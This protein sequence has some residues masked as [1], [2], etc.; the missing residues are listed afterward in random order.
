MK[1][2]RILVVEDERIVSME[3][4]DKLRDLGYTVVAS[5]SNG[6][7]A[8]KIAKIEL[9]DII[10]MDIKLKGEM[11]GIE[12]AAI[13]TSKS[14][15][16]VIFLTAYADER[17][18]QRAKHSNPYGYLLKPFETREL[19]TTVEMALYRSRMERRIAESEQWLHTTLI[20]IGDAVIATDGDKRIKFMNRVAENLTGW[21]LK[22]AD[23][24]YVSE[25]FNI[26][27][28]DT[29]ESI[30]FLDT[31]LKTTDN[32]SLITKK[33]DR[34]Q[35]EY[36]VSPLVSE[37][38]AIEGKVL[39]FRDI[40]EKKRTEKAIKEARDQ[41]RERSKALEAINN[42]LTAEIEEHNRTGKALEESEGKYYAL[43]NN[44]VDPIIIFD[45]KSK[46][47]VH[48]NESFKKVYGYSDKEIISMTPFD[49]HPEEE[50]DL[51]ES[52]ID[53]LSNSTPNCY[54][55][56]TKDG[57]KILVE[58]LTHEIEYQGKP[59]WMTI[60]R[61]I[62]GRKEAEEEK[63]R[64]I[65]QT[66]LINEVGRY[67]A[68]ELNH[69]RLMDKI[70]RAVKKTF[71]FDW[72]TLFLSDTD[73]KKLIL[74][75]FAGV[76]NNL[77]QK[78]DEIHFGKGM[79]GMAKSTGSVQ[80]SNDVRKNPYYI[81][82]RDEDILSELAIPIIG[83]RQ[84]VLGV[85]DIQSK[86]LNAFSQHDVE[87]M[88]ALS[89]QIAAALENAD[90]YKQVR[91]ELAERKKAEE[92]MRKLKEF[93][94]RILQNMSEGV[95]LET[96]KGMLL[97]VN[98]AAA[99]MLGDSPEYLIGKHWRDVIPK[100]LYSQV[101]NLKDKMKKDITEQL[102]LEIKTKRGK[103]VPV[104][105]SSSYLYNGNKC[106][107]MIDVLTDIT[108][109]KKVQEQLKRSAEDL[110]SAKELQD[111]YTK[112]LEE[113][114]KELERAKEKAEEATRLKSEF[115]A[116][117][118]HEIRTPMNGVIGMTELALDT[119]LDPVQRDYLKAVYVSAESLLTLIND[120]LDFSKMEAGRLGL[121]NINFSL[122]NV[123]NS[124]V[125][126]I[127]YQAEKKNIELLYTISPEI[128][129]NLIGDPGRIR[130]I[131]INL[132]SNALKFTEE[133]EV[134]IRVE[135]QAKVRNDDTILHFSVTDS[136]IGIPKEKQKMI[137]DVFTQADGSTTRKY[138]GT[139]LG[140]AISSKLV[141]MMG[142]EIWV[143][144]PAKHLGTD[145]GGAGSTFHFTLKL[146]VSENQ[147]SEK[148]VDDF[149][150]AG[151]KI[152][153]VDDN[154]TNLQILGDTLKKWGGRVVL[155]SGGR[156]ALEEIKK[157]EEDG[158][159]FDIVLVDAH[160]PDMDGFELA[161]KIAEMEK[162]TGVPVMMVS[163]SDIK[164]HKDKLDNINISCYVQKPLRQSDLKCILM[165]L[166]SKK[167]NR[168]D[169]TCNKA[170]NTTMAS[171]NKKRSNEDVKILLAE[172]N[173]INRKL[174]A[175]LIAKKG[176]DI[177]SVEDGEECVE[178]FKHG[179]FNIILMDVQMPRMD[180]VEA[181]RKIREIDRK[182]NIHTPIIAMTAHAMKGDR[183]KFLA[184]GMD[185]YI[186]KPMK[187]AQLYEIIG[188]YFKNREQQEVLTM[189]TDL[190]NMADVMEAVDGD[191][192]L[193]RELVHDF[194]R[195][196]PEQLDELISA[197]R[198]S[199]PLLVERKAHSFKG[200]V[201]NFG[202]K[203]VQQLAY[204]LEKM[205]RESKL[206]DA[207]DVL[208]KLRLEMEKV[209]SY[210]S[211]NEWEKEI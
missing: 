136:G 107:G 133:G 132:L 169:A 149:T 82:M 68:I 78:G 35:I 154:K 8:V 177:I 199:D 12:A 195:I 152:L 22:D 204:E 54:T 55:H 111:V 11:D 143:E 118:S 134:L 173:P 88:E 175:S 150:L 14:N 130:Q 16:P 108:E 206:D 74:H 99:E 127:F 97:F 62:T 17:T 5:V 182:K 80:V 31:G 89:T 186:A 119:N 23:K 45:K 72:V 203:N 56:L 155:A 153:A 92:E 201:G 1:T 102:D 207:D 34:V 120:I 25:V 211:S 60:I 84:R 170:G 161:S 4:E 67:L 28:D 158:K 165:D 94:E 58:V 172:D 10:L 65:A 52:T 171:R 93:H 96:K 113:V 125:R 209:D 61:D 210:F 41:L 126:S 164:N 53:K 38:I 104:L 3:I 191:R 50:L 185:D 205:G 29:N 27:N 2:P 117:M 30:N 167:D 39:T 24:K 73:N 112:E 200:S 188:K 198:K 87:A 174:A 159:Q 63:N 77:L 59:A 57:R 9:P 181:T 148:E 75:S 121:E 90:L 66:A 187:A 70:V 13:I 106:T 33:G 124:S 137:F 146:G 168:N 86:E 101:K 142:G 7:E 95:V 18:I 183:E 6:E 49:L 176:W 100:N 189:D 110:K 194:L 115:L 105:V 193:V 114:I 91:K 139:G 71:N 48:F 26:V 151:V 196:Y 156:E 46:R 157:T 122:G 36:T 76:Q 131:L 20:S 145:K 79:I 202:V 197:V 140:L 109:I 64:R 163:S 141:E 51:V 47:I 166:L 42:K 44:I 19:H 43:F 116:N 123:L 103:T 21:L 180:G 98:K 128:P 190:A 147:M 40:T 178:A 179:N 81:K 160:M 192:D 85:L 208:N 162:G 144:S 129:D 37:K 83:K 135:E 32:Y 15:I 138:G 69:K 184:A